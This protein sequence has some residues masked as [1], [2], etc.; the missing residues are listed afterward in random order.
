MID[1]S[2]KQKSNGWKKFTSPMM[3][4]IWQHMALSKK[5]VQ[6]SMAG[7]RSLQMITLKSERLG[8]WEMSSMQMKISLT[9]WLLSSE[10][11]QL[12][13]CAAVLRAAAKIPLYH[14]FQLL[15]IDN[16]HKLHLYQIPKF[17]KNNQIQ[18]FPNQNPHFCA[19]C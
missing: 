18:K 12:F 6:N 11:N 13:D 7:S 9:S 17:V 10:S 14:T 19:F 5:T 16:L 3:K 8:L 4:F 2:E 15:S 1:W